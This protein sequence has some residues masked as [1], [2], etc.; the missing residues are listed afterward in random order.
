M[1]PIILTFISILI[2][3]ISACFLFNYFSYKKDITNIPNN[4]IN[5]NKALNNPYVEKFA[6]LNDETIESMN[7][8]FSVQG[9]LENPDISQASYIWEIKDGMKIRGAINS[10]G[11]LRSV[12][13]DAL[14]DEY[15]GSNVKIAD[16]IVNLNGRS[17]VTYEE[18]R[19]KCG[20]IDGSPIRISNG[21]VNTYVWVNSKYKMTI[22]IGSSGY[23]A[24]LVLKVR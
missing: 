8:K 19:A 14:D 11:K 1:Q 23:V 4:T 16:D 6:N 2:L 17:R 10:D 7:A 24:P 3:S 12:E 9:R 22:T 15:Y 5:Y 20:E 21:R 18:V 13:L